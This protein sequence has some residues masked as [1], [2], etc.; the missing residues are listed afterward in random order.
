MLVRLVLAPVDAWPSAT[1]IATAALDAGRSHA[2]L[3]ALARAQICE[4][5]IEEAFSI[6]LEVLVEEPA[7]DLRLDALDAAGAGLELAGDVEGSLAFYEAALAT[8]G[9]D[10]RQAVPLLAIALSAGDGVR[11]S[12]ASRRLRGLDLGIPGVRSRFRA[13]LDELKKRLA[14]PG[15]PLVCSSSA[16][17]LEIRRF[18]ARSQGPAAAVADLVLNG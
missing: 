6:L 11:A 9:G 16:R 2:G 3:V 5:R 4:G 1:E 8:K 7:D 13:A 15:G 17:R 10:L 14:R 12:V 18:L